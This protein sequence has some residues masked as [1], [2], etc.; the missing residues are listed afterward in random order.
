MI[1]DDAVSSGVTLKASWD[2]LE[3]ES[4]GADVLGAGVVM[5]QGGRWRDVIGEGRSVFGV[6][7]SL[8]LKSGDGGW[9]VRE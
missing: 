6:F 8:L 9:V 4:V 3:G 5:V 2:F 7:D 1:V